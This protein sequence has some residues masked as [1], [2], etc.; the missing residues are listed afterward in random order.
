MD[1]K[2]RHG[3]EEIRV[4]RFYVPLTRRGEICMRLKLHRDAVGLLPQS[5]IA[6]G[7]RLRAD[8]YKLTTVESDCR[9]IQ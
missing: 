8:W 2:S 3:F 9:A 5:V 1:F 7:R 6:I 4:P